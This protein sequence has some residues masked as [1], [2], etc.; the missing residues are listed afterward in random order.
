MCGRYTLSKPKAVQAR[1]DFVDWHEQ[2]LEPRYNIAPSQQILT[3]VQRPDEAPVVQLAT[4]GLAPAWMDAGG[5][6][7]PPIN[8]RAES[9][10]SSGLFRGAL[11]KTRCLIPATGFYEWRANPG[12]GK[13]PMHVQVRGGE[14]FAFAGL[15]VPDKERRPTAAIIT[16][17][18]NELMRPIHERMPVILRPEDE[19]LWLDPSLTEAEM[20]VPLLQPYP[21]AAMD[22]YAVAPLVNSVANDSPE[23]IAR[24]D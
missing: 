20:L 13:T 9:V 4:W 6:R 23:L 14:P 7:R 22:A 15:W 2:P 8:A 19:A 1:F 3:I 10:A 12:G 5:G 21:A 18:A 16:T 17:G 24:R 11:A